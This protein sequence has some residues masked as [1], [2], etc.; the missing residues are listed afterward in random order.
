MY[1]S[2]FSIMVLLLTKLWDTTKTKLGID[3]DGFMAPM[4]PTNFLIGGGGGGGRKG[5]KGKKRRGKKK[6]TKRRSTKK[7]KKRRKK[8]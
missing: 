8:R 1:D 4:D 7:K 5:K 6:K 3:P 2:F